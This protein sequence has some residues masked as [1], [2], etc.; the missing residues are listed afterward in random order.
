MSVGPVELM[1]VL[2]VPLAG[3]V[4]AVFLAIALARRRR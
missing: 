4:A 2:A 3:I 1:I